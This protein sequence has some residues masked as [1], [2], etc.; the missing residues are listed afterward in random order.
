MKLLDV[1]ATEPLDPVPKSP[2][3]QSPVLVAK[4]SVSIAT[5]GDYSDAISRGAR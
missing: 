2:A 1:T 4:A 3:D 5:A